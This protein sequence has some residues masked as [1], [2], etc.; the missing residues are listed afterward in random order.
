MY[1]KDQGKKRDKIA[2]LEKKW[3]K[4]NQKPAKVVGFLWFEVVELILSMHMGT[5]LK[6][7]DYLQKLLQNNNNNSC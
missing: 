4:L 3:N 5:F 7:Q 2:V 6:L 1:K